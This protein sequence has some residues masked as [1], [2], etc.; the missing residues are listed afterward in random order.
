M[1]K[2]DY[3]LPG[4]VGHCKL[5][6]TGTTPVID[7]ERDAD[8]FY[9]G[10]L[11]I[12]SNCGIEIARL[13]GWFSPDQY[14]DVFDERERLHYAIEEAEEARLDAIHLAEQAKNLLATAFANETAGNTPAKRGPGRP[15]KAI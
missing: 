13:L 6:E 14:N 15:R 11:Y 7:T 10:R 9:G 3:Y 5:C 1:R 12:C 4:G 8:E 2:L